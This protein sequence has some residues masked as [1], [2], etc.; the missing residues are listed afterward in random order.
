M[1]TKKLKVICALILGFTLLLSSMTLAA[2]KVSNIDF[3]DASVIGVV[4]T[5][6][7]GAGLD[8]VLSGEQGALQSKKTT[9]HLRDITPE[10]AVEYVL[11][12]NGFNYERKGRVILISTLPQDLSQTA[13][14]AEVK[15]VALKSLSA[16]KG[17]ELI[18]KIMPSISVQAGEKANSLVLRGKSFEIAEAL[19]LLAGMDKPAPQVLIEGKILEVTR[20]SSLRLGLD[21]NGGSFAFLTDKNTRKI[22]LASDLSATLNFLVASGQADIVASPRIATAD[23]HEAVIN[24]G[25]RVPYAVPTRDNSGLTSKWAVEYIDAGVKLKILPKVGE[26]GLI[27]VE[28]QPEVSSVKEWRSTAAGEFPVIAARNAQTTVQVRDGETIVIGGLL[29]DG[30]R[31]NIVRLPVLG[32]LPIVGIFFQNK[33]EEKT[34]TEIIFLITPHIMENTK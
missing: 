15:V 12:T 25:T 22:S 34:K 27:T 7:R 32:Y 10:E 17:S 28:L 8:L 31:E 26:E 3:E 30:S 9:V 29:S 11:K 18:G 4:K 2:G 19:E 24:V 16:Q 20:S 33:A 23:N 21:Y 13:Y 1:Q 5:L 14:G 6:A